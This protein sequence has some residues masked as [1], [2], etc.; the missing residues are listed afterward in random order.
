[1]LKIAASK[2]PKADNYVHYEP[3]LQSADP[4]VE[5]VDLWQCLNTA[6]AVERLQECAALILTGGP[7]VNPERY[8]HA[9]RTG[10]CIAIDDQRDEL[11]LA[12]IEAA[13][14]A[15]MPVL[16]VCRGL[17]ILNVAYGG[18]LVADIPTS[19]ANALEHRRLE[20]AD[21]SH[22]VHAEGGSLVQRIC[23]SI[24]GEVNSAHHQ[25]VE[26][27]APLFTAAASAPDGCIEAIEW[28]DATLGGKPFL[29]AVQWHPERM[30]YANPYSGRIA[31]H[32]VMEAAVYAAIGQRLREKAR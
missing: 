25:A 15:A 7:D 21:A 24:D 14:E 22:V 10:L 29:L 32:F 8:G 13:R 12:L 1:M 17:Q 23:R 2:A 30:H 5:V 16:G 31:E 20:D 4:S 3:W 26:K 11:E 19:N 28:G 9:E 27:L 18:T 6:E